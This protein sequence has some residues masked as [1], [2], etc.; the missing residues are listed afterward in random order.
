MNA[1]IEIFGHSG[2]PPSG[3]C[4]GLLGGLWRLWEAFGLFSNLVELSSPACKNITCIHTNL[5][6]GVICAQTGPAC[7]PDS[8]DTLISLI[9]P[10]LAEIW[11]CVCKHIV[12]MH[13]SL[14][15]Q[16]KLCVQRGLACSD[17]IDILISLIQPNLAVIWA[18]A[19]KHI[20]CMQAGLHAQVISCA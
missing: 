9:Q 14:R 4:R 3:S 7:S 17:S 15:A 13:A 18:C 10:N 1:T 20:A 19:C 2:T 12:C 16:V 8:I 5:C 11:A 6:A